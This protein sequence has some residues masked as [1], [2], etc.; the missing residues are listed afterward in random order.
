MLMDV[1]VVVRLDKKTLPG[2]Q[3]SSRISYVQEKKR[4]REKHAV[5][6]DCPIVPIGITFVRKQVTRLN[7]PNILRT[8]GYH[9][10]AHG[11]S[12]LVTKI[13]TFIGALVNTKRGMKNHEKRPLME[14][15][16]WKLRMMKA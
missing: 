13:S 3:D 9:Q 16:T 6:W 14:H 11:N 8:E 15:R 1:E 10:K 12:Q 2:F 7:P 4:Q 5:S